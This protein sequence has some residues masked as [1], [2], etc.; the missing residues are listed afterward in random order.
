MK[1]QND[2]I[3][4]RKHSPQCPLEIDIVQG[5]TPRVSLPGPLFLGASDYISTFVRPCDKR[6]PRLRQTK[7]KKPEIVPSYIQGS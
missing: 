7:K 4:P 6:R 3:K 5:S 1:D 2:T